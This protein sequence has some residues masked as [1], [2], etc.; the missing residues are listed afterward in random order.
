[1][2]GNIKMTFSETHVRS[3][4]DF[5]LKGENNFV[6]YLTLL[7]GENN[8]VLYLTFHSYGQYILY[9]WGYDKLDTKD[10]RDLQRVGNITNTALKRINNSVTYQV[11]DE[12]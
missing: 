4:R 2:R 1:M 9:P 11:K 7:K 6:L 10:L 3:M 12:R 8:F 5:L